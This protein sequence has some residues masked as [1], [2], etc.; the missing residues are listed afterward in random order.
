V[1]E[2]ERPTIVVDRRAADDDESERLVEATGRGVL[3]VDVDRQ[4]AVA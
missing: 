2:R 4:R 3:L 1:E